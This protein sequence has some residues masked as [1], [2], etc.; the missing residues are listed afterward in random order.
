MKKRT[1]KTIIIIAVVI[2]A[3][4]ITAVII[5][6]QKQKKEYLTIAEHQYKWSMFYLKAD[7]NNPPAI[8][9]DGTVDYKSTTTYIIVTTYVNDINRYLEVQINQDQFVQIILNGMPSDNSA[10]W[11]PLEGIDVDLQKFIYEDFMGEFGVNLGWGDY[12]GF[13]SARAFAGFPTSTGPCLYKTFLAHKEYFDRLMNEA[14]PEYCV[15]GEI[16]LDTDIMEWPLPLAMELVDMFGK[17][18][19]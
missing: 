1:I 13:D 18:N 6:Q 5:D 9:N 16:P 19:P 15:D 12:M 4:I 8:H 7:V 17:D 2:I 3:I 11:R 10:L 14:W